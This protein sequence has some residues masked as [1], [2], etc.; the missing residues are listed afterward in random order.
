MSVAGLAEIR[1][2]VHTDF[3]SF[4]LLQLGLG[5]YTA[6]QCAV[7]MERLLHRDEARLPITIWEVFL[8]V[9]EGT[10]AAWKF[11]RSTLSQ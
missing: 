10:T 9:L 1:T 7:E 5:I 3:L 6:I 8:E 4:V 2:L 11:R